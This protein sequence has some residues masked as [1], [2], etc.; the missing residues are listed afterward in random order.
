MNSQL[1]PLLEWPLR[2]EI[3]SAGADLFLGPFTAPPVLIGMVIVLLI[4][5]V[6]GRLLIG[7]AL[8]LVLIALVVV[9]G[10]WLLGVIGSGFNLI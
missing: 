4:V 5:F 2:S 7:L 6:V 8:R 9:I 10:L 1:T 3:F